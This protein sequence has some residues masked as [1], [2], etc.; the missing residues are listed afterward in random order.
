M[1]FREEVEQE[2]LTRS[3]KENEKLMTTCL[4]LIISIKLIYP[5]SSRF[6]TELNQPPTPLPVT[7]LE[8]HNP[9]A[10]SATPLP[11]TPVIEYPQPSRPLRNSNPVTAENARTVHITT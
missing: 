2:I 8:F 3:L 9:A 10:L 5:P 4:L 7:E 1:W 11:V 6:Q